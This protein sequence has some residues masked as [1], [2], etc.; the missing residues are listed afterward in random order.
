MCER[1]LFSVLGYLLALET[2]PLLLCPFT[3][4][5]FELTL[6]WVDVGGLFFPGDLHLESWR[7]ILSIHS[8]YHPLS[9]S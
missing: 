1:L 8:T 7:S 2:E 5:T 4:W 3:F 6:A 9:T